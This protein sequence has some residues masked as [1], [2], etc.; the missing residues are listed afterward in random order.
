MRIFRRG[1]WAAAAAALASC[2]SGHSKFSEIDQQ[3]IGDN[4][5]D[6]VLD[7]PDLDDDNDGILDQIECPAPTLAAQDFW[8]IFNPN[9]AASGRRD[10]HVA[11]P[12]GTQVVI[13]GAAP[14]TIPASG[15]LTVDTGLT[16]VPSPNVVQSGKAIEITSSAPVQVFANNFQPFTVD[17]FTVVPV[18]LLGK[19]YRA[20]GYPNSI[21]QPSQVTVFAIQDNTTVTIGTGAPF[22]LNRGQSFLRSQVGDAT[23]L[24]VVADKPVGVNSGDSCL[25]TGA[26]ACDHVEEMLFPIDSWASDFYIPTIPQG[27]NFRVVAATDGTV[28]SVDGTVV[29]TINAGQFYTG[30]GGGKRV[31]T[32]K[33]AEVYIIALGDTSGTGDP[34]FI[35]M[36]GAQNGVGTATFS[37]LA[38]DNVNTLAIS[39][40]TA[41]ISSLRL[42]GAAVNPTWTAYSSGG[43]S[44]AQI[45]VAVG[46]HTLVADQAFIPV[47]W[48][49][50]SFESYGYVA[51]YGYPPG[52]CTQDSDGDGI[53]DSYD[54]DS[55]GD[56]VNDVD[57]AGGVDTNRDGRADGP[58]GSNGVPTSA[59]GGI[60]PP[61]TDGDG[62]PDSLDPDSDNDGVNDNTDSNRTN[63]RICRDVDTDTCDDC[64]VTGADRSGGNVANDG[65]DADGD[66]RC[67]G[68]DTDD[69]NDGVLDAF[70]SN[71]TNPNLCRDVDADSCDDCSVTGANNSGGSIGNDGPDNDGDGQCNTGDADD[72]NDGALDVND[73]DDNNR[74]VCS[75]ADGDTCDDCS[76]G[77]FNP[78]SDGIDNDGDGQCNAGDADDDNDGSPDVSDSNDND[79]HICSDTDGDTCE[80]CLSGSYDPAADGP[81]GDSDGLCNA[82][83]PDDDGDGV[84]D[85]SDNCPALANADQADFDGD[86]AGDACDA[87]DDNDG[88]TDTAEQAAGLNPHDA[89][90]D[91]D[92]IVD[93]EESTPT[94]DGDGDGLINAL[95]PDSDNDGLYDGTEAGVTAASAG[96]NVAAGHFVADADPSTTTNP[97]NRDTDG[98]GVR[99]GA[100]DVNHNGRIDAGER[101]P[102]DPADDST[103]PT[104]TDGDG[105][106]DAEEA[107]LGTNPN[108]ADSD[109]DGVIDGAE[110]NFAD[111]TDGDGVINALD[112]DSDNDGLYDGTELGVV[113]A[114]TGTNQAAGHFVADADPSSKTNPLDP[115]TD[116]GGVRDGAEDNNRDG[117]VDAGERDPN[118]AADDSTPPIIDTDHDG[119]PDDA[120]TALGTNPNDADSD[121]DGVLDGAE[122]NYSD[123]TDHDGAINALDPDSDGDGLFDGT[124][125]GV[126]VAGP[127][128]NVAAGHFIA[129]ADPTAGTSMLVADTDHGGVID[130]IEDANH[131]GRVDGSE[132]DPNLRSDDNLDGDQD[133]DHIKDIDE[134]VGDTDG[135]GVADFLDTDSDNDGISDADEAGDTDLATP[136]VDSDGDGTPDYRDLD[137]DGDSISDAGEAG[138]RDLD[139]APVDHDG[140]G[141]PDFLDLDADGDTISDADEAGDANLETAAVDSDEDGTADYLDLD[142]DGDGV[143]DANEAGDTDLAT[144][145][146]NTDGTG[147]P[148][149]RDTDADDDG[150]LDVTDNCRI[151]VNADQADVN[152][153]GIGNACQDDADGD[154]VTNVTDNCPLVAN[155]DQMNTDGATDGGD[156]CDGDDDDDNVVDTTDNCPVTSNTDQLNTDGAADGGDACDTDDDNDAVADTVDNC[157]LI[158]NPSQADLDADGKGDA[159][160]ATND[161]DTDRDATPDVADNCP[162][163]ANS[164]QRDADGDG[165]GDVCDVDDNNDGFEDG[166]TVQGGGCSTGGS[167]GGLALIAVAMMLSVVRRRRR[168]AAAGASAAGVLAAAAPAAAQVMIQENQD[169]PAERFQLS[170]SR[171][172]I[173]NVESATVRTRGAWDLHLWLGDANDPLTLSSVSASGE[174]QRVGS[175]VKNRFG[176]ELGGSMVVLPY[177]AVALD[178]PLVL[179]QD[180]NS[181]ITGVTSM[182]G[183]ISGVGLGDLR[184]SPKLRVLRR[185]KS[186]FDL[187]VRMQ[188]T[189]PTGSATSYRGDDGVSVEPT[190]MAASRHGAMRWAVDLGYL[191][192]KPKTVADLKVDDEVRLQ[193]GGAYR[194]AKPAE[195]G[196]TASMAT[197]ANDLFGTASRNHSELSAGPAIEVGSQWVLFAAAGVGLQ[198]GYGTPDWRALA[199]L[200]IGRLGSEADADE[201]DRDRDGLFGS[202]DRCPTEAEDYDHFQDEDG[203]PDPDNDGD[204]IADVADRAPMEPEDKDGFQ[205]ED[206]APDPDNDGDGVAD[207]NDHC[208]DQ[209]ETPNGYQDEDGCPDDADGDGDGIADA[210][211]ACRDAAEDLDGYEDGDGCPEA[212]NDK[213]GVADA[214]DKCP[215]EVGVAE[216][217]GCPDKDRDGDAVVDRLDNCPDVKGVLKYKGCTS[218]QVVSLDSGQ[219]GL[220]DLVYFNTDKDVIQRRSYKLLDNVAA[221]IAAHQE[222]G[223]V[224]VEGHTDSEGNES[225]NQDL[226]QRRAEAVVAYLVK[227]GIDPSRLTA[228]GF[229][230]SQPVA[231]NKSSK[232]R[233]ANRRVLFK[234]DG[235]ESKNS[236]P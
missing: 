146:A 107:E 170:S 135:D 177:L 105:L 129:D 73:S 116:H 186:G 49:E 4:D 85:T 21:G 89:D 59:G 108:D 30:S 205:D 64:A 171:D 121:D 62:I 103:A 203:C 65:P 20:I 161:L 79:P 58:V 1:L 77:T 148:D 80:D 115:D 197:A 70:D 33:P 166:I 235:V 153:D 157:A 7:A 57:E 206:G 195:L 9:N 53:I 200:R 120:E 175:L 75:D 155:S 102:N 26:G 191:A 169:F 99:D 32:S 141:R 84:P 119:L 28:V 145:P 110:P 154:G 31:Q 187:A 158:S 50:K 167:P 143:S 131:N 232:G 17:A 144:A 87:D 234:I 46:S 224:V 90:S 118:V 23:G 165:Q 138:D 189:V 227:K 163:D 111:D 47:I 37:A 55:D 95:D 159:C 199:G 218:A 156:L 151:V 82:G 35:L 18:Q 40:P 5:D 188:L 184:I 117:A 15:I 92:G 126:T 86:G 13:A 93:G 164:D 91:D 128:T 72:D 209:K 219:I 204:G 98:G 223:K 133:G 174:Q 228:K 78:S 42:D 193:V 231:D 134:G 140:D 176:G 152:T 51:G 230:S 67:N 66:G 207:A 104:D 94:A 68:G 233:A 96:T 69:D 83:D 61:D 150:V 101:D 211:D 173:L 54:P 185:A 63:S 182:L 52:V 236:A 208:A 112:P 162:N 139:T 106:S 214:A 48:G 76:S 10:V 202:A 212:D 132:T 14:A 24:R 192:R 160:D 100:E 11:G 196:V 74:F 147:A 136:A 113:V 222:V 201:G 183:D 2:S 123:D 220:I 172:G 45:V 6:G 19:D 142:T 226:S 71:P 124:E 22:V 198:N 38:A 34:A 56:G 178:L 229:G 194:V 213:D 25:N 122:A 36:P 130:G 44:Y 97:Y 225:H 216:N 217:A 60:T 179:S 109:D 168:A 149:W 81:D 27:Q 41:A 137:S 127:D 43:Y 3:V 215:L 190:L 29:G 114:P 8:L 125:V 210:K 16:R 88:L 180:R 181:T 39:M 221:V 12:P